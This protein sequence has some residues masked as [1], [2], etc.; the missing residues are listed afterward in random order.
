[1]LLTQTA[2]PL[3]P[4]AEGPVVAGEGEALHLPVT[5]TLVII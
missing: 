1:M 5:A 4:V 3:E 2:E